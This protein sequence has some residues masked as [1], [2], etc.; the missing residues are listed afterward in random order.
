VSKHDDN[1]K[2][3]PIE[4]LLD[5]VEWAALDEPDQIHP[6]DVYATH[7]GLL[8]MGPYRFRVYQLNTGER[9]VDAYDVEAFYEA[10]VGP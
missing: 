10:A 5:A 4:R 7:E 3:A 9:V 1:W 2:T 6:G 8:V